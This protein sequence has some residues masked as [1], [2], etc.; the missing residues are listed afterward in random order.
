MLAFGRDGVLT[1]DDIRTLVGYVRSLS[2]ADAPEEVRA[3]GAQLRRQLREL[4]WGRRRRV[5]ARLR[6]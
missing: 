4:P 2:G 6:T 5:R 3:A 1:R